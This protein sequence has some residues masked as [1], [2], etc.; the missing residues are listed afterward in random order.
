MNTYIP[1]QGHIVWKQFSPQTG[2][3]QAGQRLALTVS[4]TSRPLY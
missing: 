3:E 2:H 4:P 1:E